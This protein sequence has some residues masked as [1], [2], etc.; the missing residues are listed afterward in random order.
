MADD[1]VQFAVRSNENSRRTWTLTSLAVRIAHAIGLHRE[2]RDGKHTSPYRPFEREMRRRLWW[3][4][5]ALDRH[6][7]ADRGSDPI[8]IT[9]SFSTQLPLHVN[10]EDLNPD[11]PRDVQPRQEYTDVTLS[12]VIHEVFDIE[13][14]LNYVLAGEFDCSQERADE[15][16]DQRRDL[17]VACQQRIKDKYLRHCNITVPA[18]RYTML[19]ADVMIATMWLWTYRPLQKRR[20]SPNLVTISR[21]WILDIS[22]DVMEKANQIPNDSSSRP[23]S[24]IATIWVQ[25]HA[26]AVMVAELCVQTEGPS[27][28]RAWNVLDVVFDET[29]RHVA[30]SDKGRLWR[31]IKKLMKKA[32]SVRTKYLE[33]TASNLVS[34]PMNGALGLANRLVPLSSTQV[35]DLEIMEIETGPQVLDDTSGFVQQLQQNLK[36]TEPAPAN[37]DPRVST[38]PSEQMDFDSHLNQI[39]WTNW[40]SF[41]DDVQANQNVLPGEDNGIPPS[42]NMW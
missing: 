39:A 34:L 40:E 1:G 35:S 42:F 2:M 24:W 27:V 20:D 28:E 11:D 9:K 19:V 5:C 6:A 31:P 25:W 14:R 36:I 4:I 37:W 23:F 30:D 32:Q 13:R 38:G 29:A 10:D 22:V 12:L 41:I 3:Q 18:Q 26:L 8:I 17:V 16:W 33:D 21:A 15:P 7:S